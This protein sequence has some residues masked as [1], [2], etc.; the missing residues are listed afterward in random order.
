MFS[1]LIVFCTEPIQPQNVT[2]GE[3]VNLYDR[4][5]TELFIFLISFRIHFTTDCFFRSTENQYEFLISFKLNEPYHI[6]TYVCMYIHKDCCFVSIS[7]SAL[8]KTRACAF[9][10]LS[11]SFFLS[12]L[13]V[14]FFLAINN[15]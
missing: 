7:K 13:R 9:P 5:H 6:Q 8:L 2:E 4:P 14:S 3:T 11:R 10:A 1:T 12:Q 15:Q